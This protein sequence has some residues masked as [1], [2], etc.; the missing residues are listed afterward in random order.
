[1]LFNCAKKPF[2]SFCTALRAGFATETHSA[3]A[4]NTVLLDKHLQYAVS[5]S[6]L[7]IPSGFWFR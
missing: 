1:M 6:Y 5:L 3:R 4:A 2:Q 7:G